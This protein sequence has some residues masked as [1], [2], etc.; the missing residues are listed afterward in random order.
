MESS[1]YASDEW[2]SVQNLVENMIKQYIDERADSV[3][4]RQ[5]IMAV[6]GPSFAFKHYPEG[7]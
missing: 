6:V 7:R 5:V 3:Q 1:V 4:M 2:R